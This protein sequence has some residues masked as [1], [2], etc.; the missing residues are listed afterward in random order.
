MKI[1]LTGSNGFLGK[2]ISIGLKGHEVTSLDLKNANIECN[3]AREEPLLPH[4]FDLVIHCAGKAHTVPKTK[5]EEEEFFKVNYQGTVN[6]CTA[7][8]KSEGQIKNF[9]L[10]STVSVYGKDSGHQITED[11][12]LNGTTPYALSKIKAEN[13]LQ[14][15]AEEH[16]L[17]TLILRLPLVL[18]LNPPGNLGKMIGA[19]SK[20]K[21]FLI[22][23]GEARKSLVCAE[24]LAPLILRNTNKKG[25]YHLTDGMHPS[26]A[27][28]VNAIIE[29]GNYNRILSLPLWFA[30]VIAFMSRFLVVIPLSRITID[31]MTLDLT[32]DDKKARSELDWRS[33]HA[34]TKLKAIVKSQKQLNK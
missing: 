23:R 9:V 8:S 5:Q 15:W 22:G 6:L 14:S 11:S 25:I 12:P 28:I 7:I 3:L 10:I 18:G 31:K 16:T 32:F 34:L 29:G 20:Q 21:F 17:N 4:G 24:D 13:Y 1:L 19:I 26:F 2:I 27:N 33:T 30:R